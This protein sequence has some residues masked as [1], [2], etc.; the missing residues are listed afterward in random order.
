MS[1]LFYL[2]FIYLIFL[3]SYYFIYL[4][5]ITYDYLFTIILNFI[6][7]IVIPLYYLYYEAYIYSLI[8]S[9]A[10]FISAF[11]LNL[12]IKK[13]FYTNKIPFIIYFLAVVLIVGNILNVILLSNF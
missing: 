8:F 4:K 13:I 1:I 3:V 5:N 7:L 9:F 2:T 6:F 11:I 12:Q 10:L